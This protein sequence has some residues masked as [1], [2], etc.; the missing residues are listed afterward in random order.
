[1]HPDVEPFAKAYAEKEREFW[2]AE[3]RLNESNELFRTADPDDYA[4]SKRH[5][6][7]FHEWAD[8]LRALKDASL[9]MQEAAINAAGYPADHPLREWLRSQKH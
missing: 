6:R 3:R 2:E 9:A 7:L 5:S 8:A 1:M 4:F